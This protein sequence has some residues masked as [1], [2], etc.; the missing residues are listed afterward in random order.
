MAAKRFLLTS[1][2]ENIKGFIPLTSGIKLDRFRKNPVM[3]DLHDH[4]KILGKWT[5]LS[6]DGD[7]IFVEPIFNIKNPL[8]AQRKQE[9]EDDFLRGASAGL[10]PLKWGK[11]EDYGF[12]KGKLVLVESI[13][14]EGSLCPIP[15]NEDSLV[16]YDNSGSVLS[17]AYLTDIKL[18]FSNKTTDMDFKPIVIAA[19][20]LSANASDAEVTTAIQKAANDLKQ[21]QKELTDLKA[22]ETARVEK[23]IK[24]TVEQYRASGVISDELVPTYIGLCSKDFEGTKKAL[25]ALKPSAPTPQNLMQ[26]MQSAQAAAG[27]AQNLSADKNQWKVGDW[28]E[29]DPAGLDA[30]KKADNAKYIKLFAD[31]GITVEA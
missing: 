25:A 24:D 9:V 29:K 11:G 7:K 15:A 18:S 19:L 26:Q 13:L 27:G 12:E 23:D 1:Q 3:L 6:V 21:G 5:N 4:S 2:V 10:I 31:A 28:L 20:G 22:A 16:L 14:T 8:A 17:E 30:L